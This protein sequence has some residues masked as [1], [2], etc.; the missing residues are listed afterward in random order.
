VQ[1]EKKNENEENDDIKAAIKQSKESEKQNTEEKKT[2]EEK[3]FKC[4]TCKDAF[5]DTNLEFKAHFKTDWH[6]FN[7]KRKMEVMNKR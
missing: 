7:L 5:F 1:A 3:K 6:N 2:G 4:T